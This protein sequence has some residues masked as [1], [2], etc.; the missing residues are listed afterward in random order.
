MAL[1][2]D[3][4]HLLSYER[5]TG[6]A[7]KRILFVCAILIL[8]LFS[9]EMTRSSVTSSLGGYVGTWADTLLMSPGKAF[10]A[11]YLSGMAMLSGGTVAALGVSLT[12]AYIIPETSI[13][14]I[15]MGSRVA[16]NVILFFVGFL[17]LFKGRPL[18]RAI[19]LGFIEYMVTLSVILLSYFFSIFEPIRSLS[20][21]I[22]EKIATIHGHE[23]IM[24]AYIDPLI[25][26][27][28]NAIG[29][30][31]TF[32]L[33][34]VILIL[35]IRLFDSFFK[36]IDFEE[37]DDKAVRLST[38]EY[39]RAFLHNP[40]KA[41]WHRMIRIKEKIMNLVHPDFQ[42]RFKK[43]IKKW[44]TQPF[45]SFLLGLVITALTMSNA[46][47]VTLILP[48][49]MYKTIDI[50]AVVPYILGATVSTYLDT[51]F[52]A[53]ISGSHASIFNVVLALVSA[54][55]SVIFIGAF[56]RFYLYAISE[57]THIVF[58]Y[59]ALLVLFFFLILAIPIAILYL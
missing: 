55:C 52:L 26:L 7:V 37:K 54:T 43:N 27:I 45:I 58:K 40:F 4:K 44:I 32:I 18:Y 25:G 57:L 5:L 59:K 38:R 15:L 6:N 23:G 50:R 16:P 33:G 2:F 29:D 28:R 1:K 17:A 12:A 34:L 3:K 21:T 39:V 35:S 24:D 31:F 22:S 8:F 19:G 13:F 48:F 10:F 30:S 49:Y 41:A 20:D 56:F 36:F 9:M 51:L 14:H 11:A 46:V 47:S 42:E 53:I